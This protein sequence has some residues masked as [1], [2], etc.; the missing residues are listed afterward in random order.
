MHIFRMFVSSTWIDLQ[1]ERESVEALLQRFR[2]ARFSGME[3]FGS[4][5]DDTRHASLAEVDRSALYISLGIA[6]VPD[7]RPIPR[8]GTNLPC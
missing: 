6:I 5:D 1:P 4:R 2:D 8:A 7:R 3:Y